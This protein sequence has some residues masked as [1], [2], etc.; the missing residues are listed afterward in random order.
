M[1][2]IINNSSTQSGYIFFLLYSLT[3]FISTEAVSHETAHESHYVISK[4]WQDLANGTQAIGKSHGE[5]DVDK[6]GNFYV[7]IMGTNE[8]KGGVRI[9]S[10][11]GKYLGDVPNAPDDFHG[12]VIHQDKNGQEY[13]YGTSLKYKR[14]MKMTLAGDVIFSIDAVKAI[15]AEFHNSEKYKNNQAK[16]KLKLTAID[17]DQAGNLYVVDGYSLDYIH[18]FN[19]KGNY[20]A[21]F[22]GK[23]APYRFNNCHK[24]HIDPRFL[25]NRLICTD[26]KNGRLVHMGLDGSLIGNY[27]EYL[28]RPSAVAFYNDLAAVAEI[29]GRVSLLNKAGVTVK[30]LGTNDVKAEINTNITKP[31]QWRTGVF[32]APHGITFDHQGNLFITEWN[33]TGRIVRF[34]LQE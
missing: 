24:I 34:D 6:N 33:K 2:I 28:R 26:R 29:S 9:Y 18:K 19:E 21:T 23:D 22:G 16:P 5:I 25:P 20:T 27:A 1:K 17:V 8:Q 31:N 30:T 4:Q 7:S 3:L 14:I 32:T 15:P 13:I 11:E 12:F 10:P